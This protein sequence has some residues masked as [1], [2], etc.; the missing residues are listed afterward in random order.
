MPRYAHKKRPVCESCLAID[1]RSL[2]RGGLLLPGRESSWS[3]RVDG[4]PSGRIVVVAHADAV[5]LTYE[6]RPLGTRASLRGSQR[7]PIQWTRCNFGNARPWFECPS[8]SNG[9]GC[10]RK[11][12]QLYFR[13]NVFACRECLGL[14][15]GSQF[16]N[17]RDRAIRRP[18][19]IRMR[20][21]GG[22]NLLGSFPD[23]PA[24]MHRRTYYRLF[25]K[26]MAEE[27]RLLG[28]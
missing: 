12:A 9:H 7:V 28:L 3:V 22:P 13:G 25:A 27:E 6:R 20:L 5:L 19:K 8:V 17:P 18:R 23:K 4:E 15:Y 11:V 21:G 10:D 16:E 14:A 1:I 26:A 2:H 24:G